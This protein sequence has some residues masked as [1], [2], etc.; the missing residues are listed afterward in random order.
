[1][2]LEKKNMETRKQPERNAGHS[3][4]ASKIISGSWKQI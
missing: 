4:Y 1:M 3:I 2:N